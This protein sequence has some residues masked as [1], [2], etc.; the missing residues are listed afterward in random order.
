MAR[1]R[2]SLAHVLGIWLMLAVF[3]AIAG[4]QAVSLAGTLTDLARSRAWRPVPAVVLHADLS[5]E[6]VRSSSARRKDGAVYAAEGAYAYEFAGR[7]YTGSRISFAQGQD[8]SAWHVSL[9]AEMRAAQ[10]AGQPITVFVNPDRPDESVFARGTSTTEVAFMLAFVL[11]F[12]GM[13]AAMAWEAGLFAFVG[14]ARRRWLS[15]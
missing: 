8:N 9:T 5:S 15:R 4:W 7:R 3:L 10:V 14:R 13:A 6:T 12:G 1:R 11:C 2:K